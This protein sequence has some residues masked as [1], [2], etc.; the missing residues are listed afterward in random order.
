[1]ARRSERPLDQPEKVMVLLLVKLT[2]LD[3]PSSDELKEIQLVP[4]T[5]NNT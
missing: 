1:M 3:Q 4:C 2:P 5:H